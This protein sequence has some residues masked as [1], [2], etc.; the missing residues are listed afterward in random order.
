[1]TRNLSYLLG[2]IVTI[3]I[4]MWLH[5]TFCSDCH[6]AI[7]PAEDTTEKAPI[8]VSEPDPTSFPIA[9]Q[10][11][12]FEVDEASNFNFKLSAN[13]FNLPVSAKVDTAVSQ[14]KAHL[15]ENPK[16]V[17]NITGLYKGSEENT[18]AWPNLGLARANAIKNYL[19]GQGIPSSQTNTMGKLMDDMVPDTDVL[20]G[21]VAYAISETTQESE[22]VLEALYDE[23]KANPLV[24]YFKT[25][26]AAISLTPEQ[27]QKVANIAKYL[28][29]VEGATC[30]VVGHTDSV[31]SRST[32]VRLGQERADFAK[33]YLSKNGILAE[34]IVT[35]SQGPDAPIAPNT[36]EEGRAKNRRTVVTLK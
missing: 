35:S 20:L 30:A 7:P 9:V 21:P 1:M 28:D 26:E 6:L 29:K 19:V 23:I 36:T 18:T 3:L 16:K 2:I 33:S 14:L 34:R 4:G 10:D 32:N 13:D 17:L 31:G 22:D 12:D 8:P 11:G 24:L 25:G 5:F 15:L 27:R